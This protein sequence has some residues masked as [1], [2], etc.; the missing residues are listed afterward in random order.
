MESALKIVKSAPNTLTWPKFT[1]WY[2][3][4]RINKSITNSKAWKLYCECQANKA[5]EADEIEGSQY[6]EE[7][8]KPK[9]KTKKNT[10]II[11]EEKEDED[12]NKE[13]NDDNALNEEKEE[14]DENSTETVD[15]EPNETISVEEKEEEEEEQREEDTKA[16]EHKY[17]FDLE[18]EDGSDFD[19]NLEPSEFRQVSDI[20]KDSTAIGNFMTTSTQYSYPNHFSF[21]LRDRNGQPTEKPDVELP[22]FCVIRLE[23]SGMKK[24]NITQR[25]S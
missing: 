22:E 18:T 19:K 12:D 3:K 14:E 24:Y 6:E 15:S 7:E 13:E 10:P 1:S 21:V 23:K 2:S 25:T 17:Y 8:K 11:E 4:N 9:K 16:L 5:A 20:I